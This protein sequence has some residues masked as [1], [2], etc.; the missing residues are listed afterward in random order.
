[1]GFFE[2][3]K[4]VGKKLLGSSE[5]KAATPEVLAKEVESHGFKIPGLDILLNGDKVTVSGTEA[6]NEEAERIILGPWQYGWRGWRREQPDR[7]EGKSARR[8]VYGE[9]G[10]YAVEDR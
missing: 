2:F 6:S 3:V 10:R 1:M 9:K 8:D 5:A 4:S 7:R